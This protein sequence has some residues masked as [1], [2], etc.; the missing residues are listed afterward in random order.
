MLLVP[1]LLNR[2]MVSA[3]K[4]KHGWP[5]SARQRLEVPI[6]SVPDCV[7]CTSTPPAVATALL[8]VFGVCMSR[9]VP[10]SKRL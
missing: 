5:G 7:K 8:T 2:W 10:L 3:E 9:P 6:I 1:T 4:S